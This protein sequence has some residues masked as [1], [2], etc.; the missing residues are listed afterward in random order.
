M[1]KPWIIIYISIH[2]IGICNFLEPGQ[3]NSWTNSTQFFVKTL[4]CHL[5]PTTFKLRFKTSVDLGLTVFL[6]MLLQ[7][8]S[9]RVLGDRSGDYAHKNGYSSGIINCLDLIKTKDSLKNQGQ[10][11]PLE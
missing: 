5:Q 3:S 4:C 7:S 10:W 8:G 1:V 2:W 6:M 11:Q 9:L